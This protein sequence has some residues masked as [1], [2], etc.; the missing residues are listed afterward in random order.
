VELVASAQVVDL[1]HPLAVGDPVFPGQP[2]FDLTPIGDIDDPALPLCFGRLSF[3][4]HVGTHMDAPAHVIKGGKFLD[5]IDFAALAGPAVKV[6]LRERRA[7]AVD[8]DVSL[9]DLERFESRYG[10]IEPGSI[11]FLHTGWDARYQEPS[12]YVVVAD[13]GSWHWPGLSGDAAE[14]LADRQIRGVGIDTIGL[15][16]GHV[17]MTL[18][19]H[20]AVLGSGAFIVENVAHLEALP[21]TGSLALALPIKTKLGSGGPTRVI[22]L[23]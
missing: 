23:S 2:G 22:G 4:E 12:D 9:D 11:V 21:T 16:G 7:D 15:D 20:R 14:L 6:D 10:R 13:D 3:I 8:Y 5:E 18:A 1:S 19:A 17:A